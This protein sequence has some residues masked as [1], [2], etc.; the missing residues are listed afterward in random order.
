MTALCDHFGTRLDIHT[1][2]ALRRAY[3]SAFPADLTMN[4]CIIRHVYNFEQLSARRCPPPI[5]DVS[6]R[7]LENLLPNHPQFKDI[8]T[9]FNS[10]YLNEADRQWPFIRQ[11][12]NAAGEAVERD[13]AKATLASTSA[14]KASD[15]SSEPSAA[16]T[17][18]P[19]TRPNTKSQGEQP[20]ITWRAEIGPLDSRT[21]E[22][23]FRQLGVALP[24]SYHQQKQ[25]SR[26]RD[27]ARPM[28]TPYGNPNR[29]YR[30]APQPER[31]GQ[32]P[33]SDSHRRTN[34]RPQFQR[35]YQANHVEDAGDWHPDD[36]AY[37]TE[38]DDCEDHEA[39]HA[40][41]DINED[42]TSAP[43]DY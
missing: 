16:A 11:H 38:P 15:S 19:H 3:E 14:N 7:F 10:I 13:M 17:K 1:T 36:N 27:P 5:N 29:N 31:T 8:I 12:F 25:G 43:C 22:Q 32:R 30:G 41:T 42:L 34:N 35:K 28:T 33:G 21:I 6:E 23:A 18:G 4:Q 37:A 20:S 40:V 26:A 24:Q 9:L 2:N 39:A